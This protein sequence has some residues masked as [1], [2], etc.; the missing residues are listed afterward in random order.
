MVRKAPK[1]AKSGT[2]SA[3][4]ARILLIA[5]WLCELSGN[6]ANSKKFGYLQNGPGEFR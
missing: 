3:I 4:F 2:W 6:L 1:Q 5:K